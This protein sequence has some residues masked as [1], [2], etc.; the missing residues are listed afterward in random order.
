MIVA[1]SDS[2]PKPLVSFSKVT[3]GYQKKSVFRNLSFQLYPGQFAGLVGPSGA[4][5]STLLKAMLGGVPLLSGTVTVSGIKVNGNVPPYVGYVPQIETVDWDFPVTVEQV[6][7]M[8]LYR[9]SS[10]LPWLTRE[11]RSLI[12]NLLGRLDIGRYAERQIK[13]LSGGEQQRVFLARALIGDTKLLI[14]DE[15]TSGVDLKTQHAILHLLGEI[16]RKGVTILLTTHDLN[17]VARHLPW[18]ICFNKR[19]VAQGDPE[20]VFTSEILSRTYNSEMNVVRKGDVILVDDSPKSGHHFKRHTHDSPEG[21]V[22]IHTHDL[23]EESDQ[24]HS[25]ED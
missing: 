14:L 21:S 19:I 17:A 23:S 9:K 6:V 16:N 11:E 5:K 22:T 3:C 8:G 10:R 12:R 18:V 15:P 4:G 13:L 20:E 1:H 25:H 7:A 24:A 2:V